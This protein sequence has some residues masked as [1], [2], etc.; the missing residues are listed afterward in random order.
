M[1]HTFVLIFLIL[2]LIGC[3]D[4]II[5]PA[6]Q[7]T[8]ILDD[9]VRSIYYSYLWKL[10]KEERLK[11]LADTRPSPDT[12]TVVASLTPNATDYFA[13]VEPYVVPEHETRKTKYGM[14]KY[15]PYWLQKYQLRT[16]PMVNVLAPPPPVQ[17]DTVVDIGEFV[18]SDFDDSLDIEDNRELALEDTLSTSGDTLVF[19]LPKLA[20]AK[21]PETR[22]ETTYLYRYDPKDSLLNVEQEYYNWYFG[23]QLV[24]TR[25]VPINPNVNPDQQVQSGDFWSKVRGFFQFNWLFNKDSDSLTASIDGSVDEEV[26]TPEV[27]DTPAEDANNEVPDDGF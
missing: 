21:P 10:D 14:V 19:E 4:K 25:Q 18:A 9:S 8:Y 24:R 13:Y 5:C 16:A 3:R 22:T 7:S 1:R 27:I 11:Y 15:E 20:Q 2:A 12:T 26:S 6:F 23:E 17:K